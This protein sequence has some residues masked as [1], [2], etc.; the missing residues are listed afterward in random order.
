MRTTLTLCALVALLSAA[1]TAVPAAAQPA[2]QA[3]EIHVPVPGGWTAVDQEYRYGRDNLWEY[4][5]G[6][7]EIFLTYRFRELIVADFEQGDMALSVSVYDMSRPLD[8]FGVYESEKP[9]EAEGHAFG[10]SV[11]IHEDTAVVCMP[12]DDHGG[13]QSGSAYVF[14]RLGTAWIQEARLKP[15]ISP[16]VTASV[17]RAIRR[18][19]S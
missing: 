13:Y 11:A 5:N 9:A 4:I 1:G 15:S 7:A 14:R 8:A 2:G 17:L 6:A 19:K 16:A 18:L 3:E 12:N 10:T